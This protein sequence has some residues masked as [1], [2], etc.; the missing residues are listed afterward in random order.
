MTTHAAAETSQLVTRSLHPA[1]TSDV[2]TFEAAVSAAERVV[3]PLERPGPEH[4]AKLLAFV[5]SAIETQLERL[6]AAPSGCSPAEALET[7]LGD[8]LYRTRLL[9]A[10][11]LALRFAPL[12]GVADASG[13]LSVEDSQALRRMFALAQH[14]PLQVFLPEPSAGLCVTGAPQRLSDWLPSGSSDG[15]VASIEYEIEND[16]Q[17]EPAEPPGAELSGFEPPSL[18]A[19]LA[20]DVMDRPVTASAGFATAESSA[21]ADQGEPELQGAPAAGVEC[22]GGDLDGIEPHAIELFGT[23]DLVYSAPFVALGIARFLSLSLWSPRIDSPTDAMLRDPWFLLD[24][25]AATA[26]VLYIIYG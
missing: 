1:I 26:T 11:G 17:A 10:G 21:G 3:V 2:R 19:F 9:G 5:L 20:G 8:Q 14:Q 7:I 13:E 4:R 18:H 15:R 23:R 6:G 16:R 24:L 25:L 12:D 22:L